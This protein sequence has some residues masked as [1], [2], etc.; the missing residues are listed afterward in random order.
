MKKIH[1]MKSLLL[2]RNLIFHRITMFPSKRDCEYPCL[3][4]LQFLLWREYGVNP[5]YRKKADYFRALQDLSF[6]MNYPDEKY[7][8]F[9]NGL[10]LRDHVFYGRPYKN[11]P[12]FHFPNVDPESLL[13]YTICEGK[14]ARYLQVLFR[15]SGRLKE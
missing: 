11:I 5:I 14:Q 8:V 10:I 13:S 15:C 6:R 7:I 3:D 9:C 2:Q 12:H 4:S 1:A